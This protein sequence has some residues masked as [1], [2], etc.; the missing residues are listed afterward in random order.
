[1]TGSLTLLALVIGTYVCRILHIP[2]YFEYGKRHIWYKEIDKKRCTL[3]LLQIHLRR[4]T[5]Q[6]TCGS[7]LV[8]SLYLTVRI[9]D[10]SPWSHSLDFR[11]P[12]ISFISYIFSVLNSFVE[13]LICI[14]VTDLTL[15]Y[16][17][18]FVYFCY[19]IPHVKFCAE[20]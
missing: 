5:Q 19:Y 20:W 14:W 9:L 4:D 6:S 12:Y 16:S 1:M 8:M 2:L 17:R 13:I 18:S 15:K 10:T 7:S 3:F 11:I